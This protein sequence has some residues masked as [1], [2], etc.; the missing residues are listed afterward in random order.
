MRCEGSALFQFL[1]YWCTL[2]S[3]CTV[4]YYLTMTTSPFPVRSQ[5]DCVHICLSPIWVFSLPT[6]IR[7]TQIL[8][9]FSPNPVQIQSACVHTRGLAV[10]IQSKSSPSP[11]VWTH[12][13]THLPLKS[14]VLKSHSG[15]EHCPYIGF[16][17]LTG[18]LSLITEKS[19]DSSFS[20]VCNEW[21]EIGSKFHD[22]LYFYFNFLGSNS[23]AHCSGVGSKGVGA[24]GCNS[25]KIPKCGAN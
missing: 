14:A 17:T 18:F 24:A 23:K 10:Q 19:K 22:L 11:L 21:P 1:F 12:L 4:D 13:K 9:K 25:P 5:S 20:F 7:W 16:L 2:L 6:S 8:S 3:T 15:F